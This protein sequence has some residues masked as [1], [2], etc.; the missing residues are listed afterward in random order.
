[1]SSLLKNMLFALALA[2][3]LWLGYSIFFSEDEAA[4]TAANGAVSSAAARDT[5]EF[6]TRLQQLRDIKFDRTIFSD[7]RFQSFVDH[8]QPI[9]DEPVGRPNPFA[10]IGQ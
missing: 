7:A 9:V 10:P 8:R 2:V 1:M 3:I 4:L 6:L 5:Q